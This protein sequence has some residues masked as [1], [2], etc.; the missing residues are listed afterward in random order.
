MREYQAALAADP[1][2]SVAAANLAVLL[3][4]THH[5]N[6]S[7]RLWT[8]VSRNDPGETAAG[9]DLAIGSCILG[10]SSAAMQSLQ[11]VLAFSPDDARAKQM[12]AQ[13][14][15]RPLACAPPSAASR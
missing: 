8:S 5:L 2:N 10:D 6:E 1:L 11:R 9:F 14:R 3:A 13:L 15:D 4:R 12:F 7:V